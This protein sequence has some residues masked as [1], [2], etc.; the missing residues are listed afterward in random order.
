M[1]TAGGQ[2]VYKISFITISRD[3]HVRFLN[4]VR[5]SFMNDFFVHFFN[6][7]KN[8]IVC[9]QNYRYFLSISI[10]FRKIVC[11]NNCSFIKKRLSFF[12]FLKTIG[13]SVKKDSNLFECF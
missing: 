6:S 12:Y 2:A 11:S 9:S 5:S 13:R 7:S 4:F 8:D 3:G 10:D 1:T